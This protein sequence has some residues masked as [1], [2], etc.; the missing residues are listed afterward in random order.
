VAFRGTDFR[1]TGD[2]P[3][4]I[5]NSARPPADYSRFCPGCLGGPVLLTE[6]VANN[7]TIINE[8][9][10]LV[11]DPQN[12]GYKILTT[13]HSFGGALAN[14]AVIELRKAFPSRQVDLV[15]LMVP[16]VLCVVTGDI[17]G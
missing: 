14:I 16:S 15:S 12:V 5:D 17:R 2:I 3:R 11:H 7:A 6:Y 13:G 8:V 1:S 4:V 9:N 10:M